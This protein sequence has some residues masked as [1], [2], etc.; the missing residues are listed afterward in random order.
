VVCYAPKSPSLPDTQA[1]RW[2]GKECTSVMAAGGWM[3][4]R[5]LGYCSAE[6]PSC[7][8]E[9][10]KGPSHQVNRYSCDQR[11]ELRAEIYD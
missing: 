6:H 7:V 11:L 10:R 2:M 8:A 1:D 3:E 9:V 5:C 4:F